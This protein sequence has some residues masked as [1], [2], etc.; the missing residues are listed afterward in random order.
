METPLGQ[1]I[2]IVSLVT[3]KADLL[4]TQPWYKHRFKY[5]LENV[6]TKEEYSNNTLNSKNM[7]LAYEFSAIAA[8]YYFCIFS[9]KL[10]LKI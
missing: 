4:I 2:C 5:I 8:R 1:L 9:G 6:H 7:K 10:F 3:E